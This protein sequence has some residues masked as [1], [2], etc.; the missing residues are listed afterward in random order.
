MQ[1]ALADQRFELETATAAQLATSLVPVFMVAAFGGSKEPA[2]LGVGSAA[3][4]ELVDA[5]KSNNPSSGVNLLVT[6][7][8][9]VLLRAV[10]K[11]DG[12][13]WFVDVPRQDAA[14]KSPTTAA[15]LLEMVK[16]DE[17]V[18][19]PL[20]GMLLHDATTQRA[21]SDETAHTVVC[22]ATEDLDD[23]TS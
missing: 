1:Q 2:L 4:A 3:A 8:N 6:H 20:A 18:W 10:P 22:K 14:E 12:P 7:I 11:D 16:A 19:W 17:A 23:S 5:I 9:S 15:A 21:A 13:T